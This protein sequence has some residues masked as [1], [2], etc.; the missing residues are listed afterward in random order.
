[1]KETSISEKQKPNIFGFGDWTF[2]SSLNRLA[3]FA[4]ARV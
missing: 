3:K 4:S 2:D 1:M